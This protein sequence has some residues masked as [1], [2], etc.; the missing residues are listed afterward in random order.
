[1]NISNPLNKIKKTRGLIYLK[2]LYIIA[3]ILVIGGIL[4]YL[5]IAKQYNIKK[6]PLATVTS[7]NNKTTVSEEANNM[8]STTTANES[9]NTKPSREPN[10]NPSPTANENNNAKPSK[11]PNSNPSPTTNENNNAKPPQESNSNPSPTTNENNNTKPSSESRDVRIIFLH[12]STGGRIWSGGV[13]QLIK[14]YNLNNGTNYQISEQNYPSTKGGYPWS[15][16]PYDYYNLW[17]KHTGDSEDRKE[18]NLDQ[19]AA[20]FD[21]IIFKHCFPVSEIKADTGK[22]DISSSRKSLENYKLQYSALRDRMLQF[23]GKKFIVWTG[24][25]LSEDSTT[26]EQAARS[27]EWADWVRKEWD[28]SGDNIFIFD[29]E[30]LE[31][32]GGLYLKYPSSN[33]DSHPDTNLSKTAASEFVKRIIEVIQTPIV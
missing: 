15:N 22:P 17:V 32:E 10:S 27:K 25:A 14:E 28:K 2:T 20:N 29:F 18:L 11:E 19:I 31:T 23:P 26:P 1:M 13:P 30:Q 5:Y 16:Y 9:N 33:K 21:V 24:A 7:E 4:L 8:S 6:A 12:H 3:G